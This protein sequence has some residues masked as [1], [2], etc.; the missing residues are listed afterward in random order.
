MR[1]VIL[2]EFSDL[3]MDV[4]TGYAAL[5]LVD[6]AGFTPAQTGV[7]LTLLMLTHLVSDMLLIPL[8]ERV[9]GRR[10][11]RLGA[12]LALLILP[13]W[14]LA[15]W[16]WAKIAGLVAIPLCTTG[17]YQVLQGEAYASL[18]GKSGTVMALTSV[19]GSIHGV[20]SW[21]VGAS[22]ALIGLPEAMWLLLLGPI[23]LV[24]FVPP[25]APIDS[26]SNNFE[27]S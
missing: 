6:V 26:S 7:L 14:L 15:P 18:P 8:L 16:T 21:M 1:W 25:V 22:A 4:F 17:W 13:A 19:A 23:M 24:L 11:V 12:A 10:I 5:Y 20:L 2:L 27:V 3:L 9:P